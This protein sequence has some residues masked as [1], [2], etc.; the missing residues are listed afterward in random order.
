MSFPFNSD[1]LLIT[2]SE[3]HVAKPM[4]ATAFANVTK[5]RLN[6]RKIIQGHDHRLLVVVGPCSIHDTDAALEYAH[7]LKVAAETFS[8]D[9]YIVMRVYLEKPRTTI[10]WKG[11]ISD[12][13]LDGSFD[14]NQGLLRARTL[15]LELNEIGIPAATEFLDTIIPTYLSDL[16]SW[17]AVGAR[18]VES[19]THRELASGLAIPVGFKNNRDGNIKVAIDAVQVAQHPHPFLGMTATGVPAIIQ[20][21]GNDACHII[22]RGSYRAPNYAAHCIQEAAAL[23]LDAQLPPRL[24]VDCSHGNSMRDD[25]LQ[26]Q[27]V[28]DLIN[29][30]K[31]GS[32]F[33]HGIMLESNL[34]EGK[35]EL[36]K[37]RTLRYGQSITD[38]CMGWEDTL[39]W[40]DK[41]AATL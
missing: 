27:V 37:K 19:Q 18:T 22:L 40:L 9:L 6:I 1:Q 20:T 12:P 24:M 39:K 29:Q 26:H 21:K 8:N 10:G 31:E 11:L 2:P 34:I 13:H 38:A 7:R 35:Q 32:T 3:L 25:K 36:V 5:H 33:I 30:L 41:L 23:L 28:S 15:L 17:C 14:V 16:I 4:S